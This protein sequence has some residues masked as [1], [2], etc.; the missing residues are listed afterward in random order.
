MM[1]ALA[2]SALDEGHADTKDF[3][4]TKWQYDHDKEMQ[5]KQFDYQQGLNTQMS[6]LSAEARRSSASD[7]VEGLK[8]AGLSPALAS[9]AQFGSVSS[10]GSVSAPSSAPAP[11]SSS[12]MGKLALEDMKYKQSERALMEA[13]RRKLDAEAQGTELSNANQEGANQVSESILRT[14]LEDM[15]ANNPEYS[16]KFRWASALLK[17]PNFNQGSLDAFSKAMEAI[18]KPS[19]ADSDM[20]ANKLTQTIDELQL[21][22]LQGDDPKAKQARELIASLPSE[23]ARQVRETTDNI[24]ANTLLLVAEMGKTDKQSELIDKQKELI[25]KQMKELDTIIRATHHKDLIAMWEDGEYMSLVV[26]SA[27]EGGPRIVQGLLNV[28]GMYGGAKTLNKGKGA[29]NM[30]NQKGTFMRNL[31]Q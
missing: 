29:K 19:K 6:R 11:S 15:Q 24:A 7:M 5:R 2:A 25:D 22:N 13:Q 20:V 10:G 9:G 30:T 31:E 14:E 26:G 1:E 18:P 16:S 21:F 23:Q 4:K 28:L 3:I 8:R 27:L 17:N 12:G